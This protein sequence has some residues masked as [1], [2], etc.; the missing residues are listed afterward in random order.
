[1]YLHLL[2]APGL[3]SWPG[4]SAYLIPLPS[5]VWSQPHRTTREKVWKIPL[6]PRMPAA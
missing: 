2:P 6:F 1:M 5:S 3:E 4:S